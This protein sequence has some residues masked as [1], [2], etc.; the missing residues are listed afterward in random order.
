MRSIELRNEMD[1]SYLPDYPILLQKSTDMNVS[2]GSKIKYREAEIKR[3]GPF[4][5]N[6][7][8]LIF[9]SSF[10]VPVSFAGYPAFKSQPGQAETKQVE[11]TI[12]LLINSLGSPANA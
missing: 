8:P 12:L 9:S 1:K 2:A 6:I 10:P 3:T 5:E 7:Y 11:L 4:C